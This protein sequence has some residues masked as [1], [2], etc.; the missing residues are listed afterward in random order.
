M[1][2]QVR[3]VS[4]VFGGL[5]AA[6]LM[7]QPA[8]A[9]QPQQGGNLTIAWRANQEPASLD[10]HID[11]FQ[12]TWLFNSFVADPLVVL[13]GEAKYRPALAT[14]WESMPTARSGPSSSAPT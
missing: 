3:A 7:A 12:S 2:L 10:G 4:A 11:P 14:S 13:D 6:A 8:G 9:Q 1:R 5:V